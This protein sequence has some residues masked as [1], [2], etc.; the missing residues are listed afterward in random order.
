MNRVRLGP[1][2]LGFLVFTGLFTC[3]VSRL[4]VGP[5]NFGTVKGRGAGAEWFFDDGVFLEDV[6]VA[7]GDWDEAEQNSKS[8][9]K[10]ND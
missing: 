1:V 8:L 10:N 2:L 5:K 6:N 7:T 4:S 3:Q 9:F